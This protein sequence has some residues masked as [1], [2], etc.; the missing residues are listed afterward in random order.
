MEPA[1]TDGQF[2]VIDIEAFNNDKETRMVDSSMFKIKD[3]QGREFEPTTDTDVMM[4]L[5]DFADFFLQDINPGISKTGKLV[6]ELPSDATSF[7]LEVSSGYGFA[8]GD[9]ETI[10]LK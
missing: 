7:S 9:Y 2:V 6:F 8:G 4:V 5:G 10:Q 3:N 1:T